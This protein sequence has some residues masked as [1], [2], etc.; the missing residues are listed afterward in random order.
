MNKYY[1]LECRVPSVSTTWFHAGGHSPYET[2]PAAMKAMAHA[3]RL[4]EKYPSPREY[5]LVVVE[6]VAVLPD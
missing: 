5:R 4:A 1:V 3:R 2:A 6:A